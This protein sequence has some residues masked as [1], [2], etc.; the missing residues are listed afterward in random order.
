MKKLIT[1]LACTLL[2]LIGSSAYAQTATPTEPEG[3]IAVA[4]TLFKG[5][6]HNA[7][8]GLTIVLDLPD[9]KLTVPNMSFLG[10][11]GGY[12]TG[13]IYGVWMLISWKV[14]GE[15]ATLR[16][17]ND[18][19]ADSQTI[20]LTHKGNGRFAYR[21]LEGNAIRRVEG[22]KLVKIIDKMEMIKKPQSR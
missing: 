1:A 7:E 16:F 19:G 13:K 5:T 12:M 2:C 20:L 15:E 21:T 6:F 11:V 9:E 14:N 3:Q 22:R 18:I 17:T 4:D 8:T 10:P